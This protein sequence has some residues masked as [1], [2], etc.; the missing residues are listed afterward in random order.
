M[1]TED[2]L[3]RALSIAVLAFATM[4]TASAQRS[5]QEQAPVILHVEG[6][7][8]SKRDLVKQEMEAQGDLRMSYACVPAGIL[9]L[10]PVP[11]RSVGDLRTQVAP[12]IRRHV[13]AGRSTEL[14]ITI[15]QAEDRCAQVR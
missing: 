7:T 2:L 4:Q 8:A 14:T 1:N 12:I 15:Q 10:E 13:P 6:L 5:I 9:I 3:Q 11:G